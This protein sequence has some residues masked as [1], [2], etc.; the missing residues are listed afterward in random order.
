MLKG[1]LSISGH[2]GL[3]KLVAEAKNNIIVESLS[4]K[5][6]MPAYSTSKI[7][8][9]ED[10]AI[11]ADSGDIP[12]NDVFK[13][14]YELENGGPAIEGKSSNNDLKSY[15]AKILPDYDRERVYVSDMKK[16]LTW[17]NELH[18][19]DMLSFEEESEEDAAD[20]AETTDEKPEKE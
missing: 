6:R 9:L 16:V 2:G 18:K 17:Y 14:I 11:Y 12:L 19:Y 4:T 13:N 15:F 7:S 3:F 5:K 8:S 10:I 1:I 20:K